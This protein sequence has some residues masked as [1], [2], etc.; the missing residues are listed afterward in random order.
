MIRDLLLLALRQG[1]Q[2]T[3]QKM[4]VDPTHMHKVSTRIMVMEMLRVIVRVRAMLKQMDL[5]Q[6]HMQSQWQMEKLQLAF[7]QFP[8]MVMQMLLV[9]Q[10]MAQQLLVP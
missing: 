4:E 3:P 7:K 5:S 10:L 8:Q 1:L 2:V 9:S 6:S